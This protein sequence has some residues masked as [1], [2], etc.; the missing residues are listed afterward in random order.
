M[1]AAFKVGSPYACKPS[2]CDIRRSPGIR[3]GTFTFL[4][5][6][7]NIVAD[8]GLEIGLFADDVIMY[9]PIKSATDIINS[10]MT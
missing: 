3:F 5:Y 1:I 8:I 9:S 10:G 6:V 7:N 4:F 2:G